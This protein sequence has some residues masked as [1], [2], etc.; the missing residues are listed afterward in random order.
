[1]SRAPR[2]LVKCRE[3]LQA[4]SK[5]H[6]E[7]RKYELFDRILDIVWYDISKPQM[8]KT[9]H[10][11]SLM[12]HNNNHWTKLINVINE[13]NITESFASEL[14][15]ILKR[16]YQDCDVTYSETKDDTGKIIEKLIIIDWS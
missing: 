8:Y 7:L 11:I 5:N 6:N 16:E 10:V 13:Y 14:I 1:M 3:T 15:V 2:S 9:K 12:N 4:I